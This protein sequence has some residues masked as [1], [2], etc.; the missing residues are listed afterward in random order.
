MRYVI[1]GSLGHISKPLV[2][3]LVEAGHAVDVISSHADRANEIK[4]IGATPLIGSIEDDSFLSGAFRGADAVYTMIPSKFTAADMKKHIASV[5]KKYSEALMGST[6]KHVVNLS[7]IGAHMPDGCGPVSGLYWAERELNTLQHINVLHLRPGYFYYNFFNSIEMI[8]T[9]G[10]LGGNFGPDTKLV[11][12]HTDDIA[13]VAAEALL[14]TS[15][16]GRSVRYISSDEKTTNEI[17]AVLGQAIG[18]PDLK[19]VDF[20]DEQT[21]N[22]LLQAGFP[23]DTARNY[24]EMG[25]AIRNGEMFSDYFST[26]GKAEGKIP[27]SEFSKEFAAVYHQQ[28]KVVS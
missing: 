5:G 17:A 15:F 16:S 20:T 22:G 24:T 14:R 6:V 21:L 19:W 23:E 11:M 8:R 26:Q 7:S 18:K 13:E 25:A 4:N 28:E 3:K 10:I 27:L 1:T 9:A 2:G 12:A